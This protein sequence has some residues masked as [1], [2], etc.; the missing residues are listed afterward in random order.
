MA[1]LEI[2]GK[3]ADRREPE[4][5]SR[6]TGQSIKRGLLGKCPSCGEGKL[7]R[8]YLKSVDS[9][10]FCGEEMHH[11]R[12]DDLPAYLAIFIVG[13]VV[14]AG[15]MATDSWLILESWQHLMIW[16]PI[17]VILSLALLQPI[18]GGVIGLQWAF[19]MH[20]FSGTEDEAMLEPIGEDAG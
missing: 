10:A 1:M 3:A 4:Q 2:G 14:V 18:K 20:G 6:N 13:H 17:T 7:F 5:E 12:A 8:A 19:R 11:H 15:F 16:I 9:C